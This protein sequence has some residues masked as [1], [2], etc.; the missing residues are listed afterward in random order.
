MNITTEQPTD[1]TQLGLSKPILDALSISGYETPTPI[2][3]K[4]I[5]VLMAGGDVLG[6]AQ[7]GT[8][9]TAAFALPILENID[10]SKKEPQAL[11][12][13]PTRELA[14]QVCESF[15]KYAANLKGLKTLAV[16]GGQDYGIQLRGLDRGAHIVVG[17]PGRVM[18]HM[19]R[20]TLK[21]DSMKCLVL[22]E[23]DEMLRMGFKEDV[24]WILE[25]APEKR[26]IA[27]F[28]ATIPDDIKEITRRF[29]NEPEEIT[30]QEKTATVENTR[31]RYI[32]ASQKDKLDALARILEAE[33]FDAVLIFAR[34]KMDTIELTEQ[35][36]SRNFAAA[37]LN[38]DVA[39]TQRERLVSQLRS[40]KLNIIVATDIAARGLDVDRIS[41]VINY[42]APQ[43]AETYVHRIG[44]TGRAGRSGEAILFLSPRERR[45]LSMIEKSTRQKIES[46]Q[47]PTTEFVNEKRIAIFKEKIRGAMELGEFAFFRKLVEQF[48]K[49][50]NANPLDVA[51]AAAGL[52]Q[53]EIPLLLKA[54]PRK[55]K[56]AVSGFAEEGLSGRSRGPRS[57]KREDQELEEGMDRYRIEVGKMH[58]VLPGHIVGA[59]AGETG[60]ASRHIGRIRLFNEFSTVDLPQGM[61]A[62]MLEKVWCAWICRRQIQ[63]SLEASGKE[64]AGKTKAKKSAETKPRANGKKKTTG[65]ISEMK[66]KRGS[67]KASFAKK[68]GKK[69]P[70]RKT[71][72]NR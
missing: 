2:Q 30:I 62:E 8:G 39:Q 16:Y 54:E 1:F 32:V 14:L 52:Y 45:I 26:Q 49:E 66:A 36:L 7:T 67:R 22:D 53:G 43:D 72:E 44:R 19:N 61:P 41:H 31:Q 27:M 5:P 56:Q 40:G 57:E 47:L 10:I 25:R 42:D 13:A 55:G 24:E 48:C 46:M 63:I 18:D 38:G 64:S 59:I 4:M 69:P 35:L 15:K 68:D 17:T 29:L 58:G 21:L 23:A 12:L 51:A 65:K 50:N 6:Q 37:A 3:A 71:A 28:S 33:S 60:M 20:Q 9:K 11:V 34:T 70:K